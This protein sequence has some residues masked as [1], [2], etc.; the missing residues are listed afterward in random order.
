MLQVSR[1]IHLI[2]LIKPETEIVADVYFITDSG[3]VI[4]SLRYISDGT[5]QQFITF[6]G[7][8]PTLKD[9]LNLAERCIQ[10]D[11]S[12]A[13]FLE[14]C[15]EQF[16]LQCKYN[17]VYSEWIHYLK[18]N[19]S[20]ISRL[21]QIP[22]FPVRFFKQFNVG[23]NLLDYS[24]SIVFTS[25]TTT[26][27]QPSRHYVPFPEVYIASF[28]K[29]FE[30]FY[31][32]VSDWT[33]FALLP[34][35]LERSGSSLVYMAEH[36]IQQSKSI[37]GGFYLHDFKSLVNQLQ[38]SLESGRK[39]MLLG[40][41]FGLLDFIESPE[42]RVFNKQGASNLVVMETG[43]MK[44]R[45]RELTRMELHQELAGAF[46]VKQIHSEYGMTELLS[47]AYSKGNG[48]FETP[49]WMKVQL[50][51]TDNPL[52]VLPQMNRVGGVNIID[53]ANVFSCPFLSI[54]DLGKLHVNQHFEILGRFDQAEVRGCNLMLN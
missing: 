29:G 48:I 40:V 46:G 53:L 16:Y 54:D 27:G 19:P 30:K 42:F 33:I 3:I 26:G 21:E 37:G 47:Q 11:L 50:R 17:P 15:L 44:G 10:D 4:L 12:E 35:Y 45:R 14:L 51:E 13:G 20:N 1:L 34:G 28:M 2:I 43:G 8:K 23:L 41:S 38:I 9:L 52:A 18:V 7:M 32:S 22:Y 24:N 25:S 5:Y 39:T 31:G 49:S 6:A 36:L